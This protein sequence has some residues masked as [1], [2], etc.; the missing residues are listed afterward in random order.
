[1]KDMKDVI[2]KKLIVLS[3]IVLA[4]SKAK[5]AGVNAIVMIVKMTCMNLKEVRQF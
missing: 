1:M 3:C 2:V 5:L 4:L